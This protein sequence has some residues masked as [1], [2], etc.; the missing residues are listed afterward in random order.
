MSYND[1]LDDAF[2]R[3]VEKRKMLPQSP[4]RVKKHMY[5][6]WSVTLKDMALSKGTP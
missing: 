2:R 3:K 1:F 5:T 4:K 6:M